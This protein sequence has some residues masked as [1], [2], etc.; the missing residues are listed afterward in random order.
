[1]QTLTNTVTK[2]DVKRL[3]LDLMS[4]HGLTDWKL[5]FDNAK[6]RLGLCIHSTKTISLSQNYLPLRPIEET[7]N[8]ILHEIAHALVGGRHGHDHV[9]QQ[10]ARE[11]GCDGNRLY[12]G[13][14]TVEGKYKLTCPNC[15]ESHYR[16]KQPKNS[17]KY[18]CRGCC[19]NY[20][21]GRFS[22]KFIF[23]WS[24]NF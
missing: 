12:S 23:V 5:E 21:N 19:D 7:K 6:R 3:A 1:M 16:Y 13:T 18:A 9:W 10:K 4:K 22:D 15:G 14:A 20:N 8:T 2:G 24:N 17:N 11:I